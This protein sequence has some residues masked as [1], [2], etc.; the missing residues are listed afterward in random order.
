MRITPIPKVKTLQDALSDFSRRL[1][2]P[3]RVFA[4]DVMVAR[5]MY[6]AALKV[7]NR[8]SRFLII[9]TALA[10]FST[11]NLGRSA[12]LVTELS[13]RRSPN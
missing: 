6:F 9:Y 13:R 12:A 3:P 11:F 8:A 10:V 4:A 7:K 5:Q 2:A 1:M